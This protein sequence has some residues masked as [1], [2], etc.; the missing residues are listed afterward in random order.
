MRKKIVFRAD[1]NSEIGLGHIYRC[2]ALADMLKDDFDIEFITKF[3]SIVSPIEN[4]NCKYFF[5]PKEI[6]FKD[7]PDFINIYISTNSII[8]IDGYSFDEKYQSKIKK[9]GN[10]L[11]YVDDLVKGIQKADIVINHNPGIRESDYKREDYTQLA[12]GFDYAILRPLFLKAA[13]QTQEIDKID[14]A[15]VCFGG[16]DINDFTLK[17]TKILLEMEEIHY[18]NIV[19]GGVY[20]KTEIFKLQ[21]KYPKIN[22]YKNLSEKELLKVMLTSDFG[23]VPASTILLELL[24]VNRPILS[25]Y[26]VENQYLFYQHLKNNDLVYGVDNFNNVEKIKLSN[27]IMN[28][29]KNGQN[30]SNVIDGNQKNRIISLLSDL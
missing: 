2:I 7:E 27:Q 20:Q 13:K 10:K 12:L 19:V 17:I 30:N 28:I 24:A 26:Y 15:F 14:T 29:I 22:I 18:I 4:I 6:E 25:G 16:S 3:D 11:V 1:G 21:E 9:N 23:V 8:I 5:I